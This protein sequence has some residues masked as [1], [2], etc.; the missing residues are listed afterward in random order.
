MPSKKKPY[1]PDRL[2]PEDVERGL[3]GL[4]TLERLRDRKKPLGEDD[5]FEA[6]MA[7]VGLIN[8]CLK[9]ALTSWRRGDA[10]RGRRLVIRYS[11]LCELLW[12]LDQERERDPYQSAPMLGL[13]L[14]ALRQPERARRVIEP[15]LAGGRLLAWLTEGDGRERCGPVPFAWALLVAWLGGDPVPIEARIASEPYLELARRWRSGSVD[16]LREAFTA[17][18]L[19]RDTA[20]AKDQCGTFQDR[21]LLIEVLAVIQLRGLEAGTWRGRIGELVE[22]VSGLE[23]D[24]PCEREQ[25][26]AAVLQALVDRSAVE[27]AQGSS[28][29]EE[30]DED[31]K[32]V[33]E[34]PP[35]PPVA[36]GRAALEALG[37]RPGKKAFLPGLLHG[38]A[39][40]H[41]DWRFDPLEL[42]Q[43]LA[44]AIA[45]APDL[46][47]LVTLR[48]SRTGDDDDDEAPLV[49]RVEPA[50]G[51]ARTLVW[52]GPEDDAD[53]I[54]FG[55]AKQL[56]KGVVL[57]GVRALWGDDATA[58]VVAGAERW[59]AARAALGDAFDAWFSTRPPRGTPEGEFVAE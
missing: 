37:A 13:L 27:R 12:R 44:K 28:E 2:E 57:A 11:L 55:L 19:R 58:H 43:E 33:G 10:E 8:G 32:E 45:A 48:A 30:G 38:P 9:D 20:R 4:E 35:D 47:T 56:P 36:A 39:T 54:A 22:L 26:T 16:E 25:R 31:E 50:R 5:R 41:T 53:A 6:W 23:T 52:E 40:V 49:V 24:R 21:S 15:L 59:D 18:L 51:K 3:E 1:D 29:D 17:L 42:V 34:T 14:L 7:A 46:R